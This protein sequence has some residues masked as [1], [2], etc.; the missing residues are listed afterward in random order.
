[1]LREWRVNRFPIAITWNKIK[2]HEA[3][4]RKETSSV[5]LWIFVLYVQKIG[6]SRKERKI[7]KEEEIESIER[8]RKELKNN[9]KYVLNWKIV[10]LLFVIQNI[11]SA[12]DACTSIQLAAEILF[13]KQQAKTEKNYKHIN[14]RLHQQ[15]YFINIIISFCSFVLFF[16]YFRCKWNCFGAPIAFN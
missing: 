6:Q 3:V 15:Q 10:A 2:W 4:G 16:C 11:R 13:L 7:L 12:N 1:M 14:N 9:K 5:A 8:K